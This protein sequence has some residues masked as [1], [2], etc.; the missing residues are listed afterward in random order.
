MF[1]HLINRCRK[2]RRAVHQG[3][4]QIEQGNPWPAG[5]EQTRQAHWLITLQA[6]SS[7]SRMAS[8]VAL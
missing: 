1:E 6:C 7:S 5:V 8:M 4:V 2:I 3:A